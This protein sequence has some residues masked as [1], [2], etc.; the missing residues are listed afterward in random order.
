MVFT[1]NNPVDSKSA[2]QNVTVVKQ[3][4][5]GGGAYVIT[6]MNRIPKVVITPVTDEELEMLM[7]NGAFVNMKARGFFTIQED[8]SMTPDSQGN[9]MDHEIK[10]NCSQ[11]SDEDHAKGADPRCDHGGTRATYGEGNE[12]G[13]QQ[14]IATA[15]TSYGPILL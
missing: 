2:Q 4:T 12:F 13:G 11:I 5:I 7:K 14:P 9:P 3:I 15:E 8:S 6:N 1:I 10:D